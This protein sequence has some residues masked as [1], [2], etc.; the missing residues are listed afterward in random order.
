MESN[1]I[2]RTSGQRT[3]KSKQSN[4]SLK[5]AWQRFPADSR[6]ANFM[7]ENP[8]SVSAARF[9]YAIFSRAK[10]L[11]D[12]WIRDLNVALTST[13]RHHNV[14]VVSR[15]DCI[16]HLHSDRRPCILFPAAATF[17]LPYWKPRTCLSAFVFDIN[18]ILFFFFSDERRHGVIKTLHRITSAVFIS[19]FRKS[20]QS[21][22]GINEWW[23]YRTF[24]L[25]LFNH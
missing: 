2:S 16:G 13:W 14:T 21:H 22:V 20:S 15:M 19:I 25:W 18:L 1:D 12:V 9:A 10:K 11:F 7:K 6:S 5:H 17:F 4:S 8:P 23:N 24:R 3:R